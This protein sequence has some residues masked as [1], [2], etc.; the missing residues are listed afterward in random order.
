[1]NSD[2]NVAGLRGISETL[3]TTLYLRSCETQRKDGIIKDDYSVEI[4]KRINYNFAQQDS[5]FSQ[6]LIAI[7]TEVIDELVKN[8]IQQYPKATIVSLGT[9]LCTRYFRVDNGLIHWVCID[10]P[11]VK[12]IWDNLIDESARLDYLAYSALDFQWIQKVKATPSA[13]VLIIAEGLLMYF[14]ELEVKQ[15]FSAIK[16]N[17]AQAEI[18][19]DSLGIFLAKHSRINSGE[20]NIDASYKW[21]IKNLK[22]IET[23]DRGI[24]LLSQCHYLDRHKRRLGLMGWLSYLP[25]I[26]NQVKI[27]HFQLF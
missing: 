4:V 17:F 22:E 21:G 9:G 12:L 19:F 26:R 7:R 20:L 25:M 15:L 3:L 14:S 18:V 13:K 2:L 27:G 1:M 11:E 6:A 16:N 5:E 8:F 10:L 24:K 23:W